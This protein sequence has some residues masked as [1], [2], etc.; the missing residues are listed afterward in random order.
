MI[1]I[2][3]NFNEL[4]KKKLNEFKEKVRFTNTELKSIKTLL[5]KS[6][7]NWIKL[8][9]SFDLLQKWLCDQEKILDLSKVKI[10]FQTYSYSGTLYSLIFYN[11]VEYN[12]CSISLLNKIK[13]M[14]LLIKLMNLLTKYLS[15]INNFERKWI[16]MMILEFCF[17]LNETAVS[18]RSK[19]L[20]QFENNQKFDFNS[21]AIRIR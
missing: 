8:K 13:I 12:F 16:K 18:F 20:I 19:L 7:N 2:I 17:D 10:I 6:S 21:T 4:S 14:N 9:E 3:D 11:R 15:R 5:E 1:N